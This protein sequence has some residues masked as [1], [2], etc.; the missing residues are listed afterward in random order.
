MLSTSELREILLEGIA[1]PAHPLVLNEQRQ[2]DEQRQRGLSRYYLAAGAG[3]LAVG[4]HTTQFAIHEPQV[5]L[6]QPVLAL[7]A[8]EM[9]RIT[10]RPLVRV[11][12]L[13][14][15]TE[16]AVREAGVA[17]ELGYNAGLLGLT[18]MQ[19]A[20]E[21][22]MIAHCRAVAEVLP[23]FG[24]YLQPD[25][26]GIDLP[27]SFWRKFVEIDNVVAIKIAAFDRY[28]T[29]DVIRALAESG[30]EDVALYTG[31][32][33]NIVQDLLTTYRIAVG[34]RSVEKH[35]SGGLLGHWAVWTAQ[36]VAI[37]ERAKAARR[38]GSISQELMICNN[39]VTDCNAVLFDAANQFRGV[40]PGLL[41][42]LRRQGLVEGTW[43]LDPEEV[44]SPGQA[45]EIDRL[46]ASY[47]HLTDDDFVAQNRDTWLN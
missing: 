39:E 3:G 9:N 17:R 19:G 37:L 13:I 36:A 32:D 8:E 45:A 18:A 14:G 30:R 34:G 41:E 6:Y 11:A 25:V 27:Y 20:S 28:K 47:P 43:C 40:I 2:L 22:E 5:G 7:A 12:G 24:F 15:R 10:D 4:V 21:A 16:Q 29:F 46:Y 23:V 35:F 1:I 44:L 42:V 33:D 31:N 38:G 26:G